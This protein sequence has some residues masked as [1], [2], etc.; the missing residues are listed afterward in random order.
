MADDP[1]KLLLEK[2]KET[3]I[4]LY[5]KVYDKPIEWR[6]LLGEEIDNSILSTKDLRQVIPLLDRISTIEIRFR[7]N[8][9]VDWAYEHVYLHRNKMTADLKNFLEF[10]NDDVKQR[11]AQR[12]NA[13]F[14]IKESELI[15]IF[16]Q[17]TSLLQEHYK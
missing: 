16:N 5:I 3:N 1:D 11:V 2:I 17:H 12:I 6:L 9:N 10:F 13:Y 14:H 8:D 4:P 15:G 7:L